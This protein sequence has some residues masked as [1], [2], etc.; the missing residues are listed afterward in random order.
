MSGLHVVL[1]AGGGIGAAVTRAL[2]AR[3][4][5]VRAV[6]RSVPAGLPSGVEGLA[7]DVST[8]DGAAR[9]VRGA[10]VVIH[11]AQPPLDRWL[12]DFEPLTRTIADATGRQDARLVFVDNLYMYGPHDGPIGELTPRRPAG[13]KAAMRERMAGE[14]LGRREQ[15]DVVVARLADYYGPGG[16]GSA[17]GEPVFASA[18]AG[19][20]VRWPG[21][22]GVPHTAAYLPDVGRAVAVLAAAPGSG[23]GVWHLPA[24]EPIDG[25]AF[26]EHLA[27]ALGRAVDV[28][29][30]GPIGYWIASRFLP[31][32]RELAETQ[33]QWRGPFVSD[34]SRFEAAFGPFT[35]T[36]HATA[37]AQT[38]AWWQ[39]EHA[40]H[41]DP[42]AVALA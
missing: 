27:A 33:Y 16:V 13:P 15:L 14:L 23:G 39:G 8:A 35:V 37:I 30:T 19:R 22:L 5:E 1:G 7:A 20:K 42:R 12:A 9:A 25:T 21:P 31:V 3:G 40:V 11:A 17:L 18:V 32:L 26:G 36:P 6:G 34:H 10:S 4:E 2:V 41:P 28:T 38:A 24:A 29:G